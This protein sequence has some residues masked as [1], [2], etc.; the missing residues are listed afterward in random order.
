MRTRF[1]FTS[2]IIQRT[3]YSALA[4]LLAAHPAQAQV[5]N[6]WSGVWNAEGTLF[7]LRITR[8]NDQLLVEPLESLGFI[9]SN[10]IGRIHGGSDEQSATI[11]VGYQGATGTLLVQLGEEGTAT[12]RPVNCQPDF[13]V[14]CALVQNQQARFVKME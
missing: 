6:D 12:V 10:G 2:R 9:W 4:L 8:M 1:S 5:D 3:A 11:E 14:V 13:H 7:S